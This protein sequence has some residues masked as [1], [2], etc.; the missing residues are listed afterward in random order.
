[1]VTSNCNFNYCRITEV[2]VLNYDL[3]STCTVNCNCALC[4]VVNVTFE[5]T[6]DR[7]IIV[8]ANKCYCK[9]TG[10]ELNVCIDKLEVFD[11]VTVF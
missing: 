8:N 2:E 11:R 10:N 4:P 7:L 3:E 1:M 6:C 5:R 9:S